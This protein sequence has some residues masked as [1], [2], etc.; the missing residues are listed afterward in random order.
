[1][2]KPT[3]LAYPLRYEHTYT[4]DGDGVFPLEMLW[5]DRAVPASAG[6]A[7]SISAPGAGRRRVSLRHYSETPRWMPEF[8][9]WRGLGWRV[10]G[11]DE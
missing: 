2:K 11:E 7:E 8:M 10:V 9:R 6:D 3:K 1:M 5:L 4:V